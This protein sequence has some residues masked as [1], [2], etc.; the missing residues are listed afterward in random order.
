MVAATV[1]PLAS[2]TGDYVTLTAALGILVGVIL[3]GAGLARLAIIADFFA[4][5]ILVGFV[6]GLALLIAVGQAPKLFGVEAGGDNFFDE[7][8]NLVMDVPDSN[9]ETLA[10]GAG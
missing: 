3:I 4:K 10:I 2:S 1:A 7:L 9:P 5:P 8:W 6:A